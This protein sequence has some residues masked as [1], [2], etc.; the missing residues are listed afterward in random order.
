MVALAIQTDE[1]YPDWSHRQGGCLVNLYADV[2]NVGSRQTLRIFILY[3][4]RSGGM[5]HEG[6]GNGQAI[7]FA[8][9]DAIR[10]WLWSTATRSCQL[11]YFSSITA[12]C[13][14]IYP[15]NSGS[16]FYSGELLTIEHFTFLKC[17]HCQYRYFEMF[18]LSIPIF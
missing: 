14:L 9:S 10:N 2:F 13:F 15:T 3:A 8:F 1:L 18:P 5:A 16:K 12:K 11:G 17:S 7:E 4:R 6:E